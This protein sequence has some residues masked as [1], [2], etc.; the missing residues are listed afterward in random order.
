M[1]FCRKHGVQFNFS[2]QANNE[3][4]PASKTPSPTPPCLLYTY[5]RVATSKYY[6]KAP[7]LSINLKKN[8]VVC[9]VISL[10]THVCIRI[11]MQSYGLNTGAGPRLL[12]GWL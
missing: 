8:F 11:D 12:W 6:N 3:V 2:L 4:K 10:R 1:L 7:S 5:F 9:A